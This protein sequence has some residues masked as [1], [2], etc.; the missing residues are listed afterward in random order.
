MDTDIMASVPKER[1]AGVIAPIPM[2][3]TTRPDQGTAATLFR[4]SDAASFIISAE[5]CVEGGMQRV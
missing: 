5:L 2:G 1:R 4:L 3:R